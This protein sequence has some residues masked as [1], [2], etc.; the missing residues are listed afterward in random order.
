MAQWEQDVR[1]VHTPTA[2]EWKVPLSAL[3]GSSPVLMKMLTSEFKEGVEKKWEIE[4]FDADAI[5][6][7]VELLRYP[8]AGRFQ[9]LAA[10]LD[11]EKIA[12]L[13][14]KYDVKGLLNLS[15]DLVLFRPDAANA[16]AID[17]LLS[18][19]YEWPVA[20]VDS[21]IKHSFL[22]QPAFSLSRG[23]G[24]KPKP[25]AFG[26]IGAIGTPESAFE[27]GDVD[28]QMLSSLRPHTLVQML[29]RVSRTWQPR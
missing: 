3:V 20:V 21:L 17:R 12:G 10:A 23:L 13:I 14:D 25:P 18:Q 28:R 11:C 7:F 5:A 8:G 24:S 16:S 6:H 9:D 27:Y 1:I 19:D 15:T 4:D 22:Q 29:S 26:A 2:K